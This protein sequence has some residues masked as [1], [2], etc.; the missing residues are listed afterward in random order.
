MEFASE[1]EFVIIFV[2][3]KNVGC[4]AATSVGADGN[5]DLPVAAL[6]CMFCA[7]K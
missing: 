3:S 5:R 1:N 7:A 2:W 6:I 4:R